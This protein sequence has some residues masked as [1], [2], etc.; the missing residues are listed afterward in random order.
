MMIG[1]ALA[2]S[3]PLDDSEGTLL[4]T[5]LDRKGRAAL[6]ECLRTS[7][8]RYAAQESVTL[9]TMPVYADGKIYLTARDGTITVI[10]PGGTFEILA[11]NKMEEQMTSSPA[12]S[13]GRVYLRTWDA[14]YSIAAPA[15]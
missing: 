6:A 14:L 4:P 5:S 8:E 10:K 7:G 11:Q 2:T 3:P 13:G 12:I 1:P 9:S 15:K